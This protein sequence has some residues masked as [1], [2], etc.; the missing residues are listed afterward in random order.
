MTDHRPGGKFLL[1]AGSTLLGHS[2]LEWEDA[3]EGVWL[4][5][6]LF[7]PADSYF[8]FQELFQRHTR[9]LTAARLAQRDY[10]RHA[11]E[12]LAARIEDPDGTEIPVVSFEL[13]DC[14][15]TLLEDPRELQVEIRDRSIREKYFSQPVA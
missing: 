3:G 10:D 7:I 12:I 14:A 4:R 8:P 13:Q 2:E 5:S 1:F 6:G 15:D 11:L 9:E